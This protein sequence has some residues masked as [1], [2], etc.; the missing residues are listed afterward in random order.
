MS[1]DTSSSCSP[2][3]LTSCWIAEEEASTQRGICVDSGLPWDGVAGT[4]GV[5]PHLHPSVTQL[6]RL[7]H[8]QQSARVNY[9]LTH[10]PFVFHSLIFLLEVLTIILIVLLPHVHEL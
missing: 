1:S 10:I 6:L 4:A 7:E 2:A 8:C 3:H 9:S 5:A